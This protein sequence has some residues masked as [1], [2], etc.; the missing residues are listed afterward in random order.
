MTCILSDLKLPEPDVRLVVYNNTVV[1]VKLRCRN[2]QVSGE[3]NQDRSV[4]IFLVTYLFV[5]LFLFTQEKR[6]SLIPL[7]VYKTLLFNCSLICLF[8]FNCKFVVSRFT[9]KVPTLYLANEHI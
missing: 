7:K 6:F 5:Y 1:K 9:S 3:T 8:S 4:V 2:G